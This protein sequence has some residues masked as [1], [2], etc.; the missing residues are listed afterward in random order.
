MEQWPLT[1]VTL[2]MTWLDVEQGFVW[3][4]LGGMNHYQFVTVSA[5][6][7][8]LATCVES[9]TWLLCFITVVDCGVLAPPPNGQVNTSSGTTYNQVATYSCD[10]G[11]NLVGSSTRTCQADTMWSS[12]TP[13]CECE[14]YNI[15]YLKMILH[16][17]HSYSTLYSSCCQ[18]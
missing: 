12:S 10:T 6:I 17:P 8:L 18:Q 13:V 3:R 2:A 9:Y 16:S 1:L 4:E 11:Y 14:F 7:M 5:T 15:L